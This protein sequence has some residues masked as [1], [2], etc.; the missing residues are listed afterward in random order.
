M[1]TLAVLKARIADELARADLSTQIGRAITSAIAHHERR[2]FYWNEAVATFSTVAAQEYYSTAALADI[3]TL[4]RIDSLRVTVNSGMY[5]LTARSVEWMEFYSSGTPSTGDPTDYCY[6]SQRIRL[7]PVPAA[8]RTMTLVYVKRLAA[9]TSDTQNNAWTDDGEELIRTRAKVDLLENVIREEA[10]FAEA[11]RL[12][13]REAE[14]LS[15]IS[16][17]TNARIGSGTVQAYY[18]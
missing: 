14:I 2:R 13:A 17:E 7:Y 15:E 8:V 5:P 16:G 18:L 11:T 1:A 9:L 6:H 4:A 12:R 10:G 3:A